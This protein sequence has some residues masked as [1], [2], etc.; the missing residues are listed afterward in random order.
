ME[1]DNLTSRMNRLE[2]KYYSFLKWTKKLT[3]KFLNNNNNNNN[4]K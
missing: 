3:K 1:I 4:N 2:D